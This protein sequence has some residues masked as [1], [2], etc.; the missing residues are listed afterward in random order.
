V[1]HY[2]GRQ[3]L[4]RRPKSPAQLPGILTVNNQIYLEARDILHKRCFGTSDQPVVIEHVR[5]DPRQYSPRDWN[6]I[7]AY[8]SVR[9]LAPVLQSL[10]RLRLEVEVSGHYEDQV[11]TMALLRWIRAVLNSRQ[12]VAS[13]FHVPLESIDVIFSVPHVIGPSCYRPKE[14]DGL[15]QA[16]AG[17]KTTVDDVEVWYSWS[18]KRPVSRRRIKVEAGEKLK[19]EKVSVGVGESEESAWRNLEKTWKNV[20]AIEKKREDV[21]GSLGSIS[22]G[23]FMSEMS[24]RLV[25][26]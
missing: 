24:R 9:E 11:L 2:P 16:V 12:S 23:S 5:Y 6:N 10:P 17:I 26:R 14:G 1:K 20:K 8:R 18:A 7:C 3:W 25:G 22:W 15:V 21:R 4:Y 13:T 19:V